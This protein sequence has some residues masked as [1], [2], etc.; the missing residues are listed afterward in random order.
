[1]PDPDCLQYISWETETKGH[2][3]TKEGSVSVCLKWI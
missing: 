3:A 2:L 1:M